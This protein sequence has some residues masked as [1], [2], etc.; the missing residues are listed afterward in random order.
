MA[1]IHGRHRHFCIRGQRGGKAKGIGKKQK[2]LLSDFEL[3][4]ETAFCIRKLASDNLW[5]V[6]APFLW[7]PLF[8]RT[9]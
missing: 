6:G 3:R 5:P 9:C 4:V 2:L 8:G 7:G 1:A